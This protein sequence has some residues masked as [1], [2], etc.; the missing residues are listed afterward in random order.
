VGEWVRAGGGPPERVAEIDN[1]EGEGVTSGSEREAGDVRG[2]LARGHPVPL[3]RQLAAGLEAAIRDGHL[4]PGARLPSTRDLA[5]RLGVDRSTVNA[6]YA[7]LRRRGCVEGRARGRLAVAGDARPPEPPSR[8]SA[9]AGRTSSDRRAGERAGADPEGRPDPP[10]PGTLAADCLGAMLRS[11]AAA[12]VPRRD[13][14]AALARAVS[15]LDAV[16]EV[17]AAGAPAPAARSRPGTPLLVEPRPGLRRALAAELERRLGVPV[18]TAR[19]IPDAGWRG[20]VL[21]RPEVLARPGALARGRRSGPWPGALEVLPLPLA[22][23]TRERGLVR[24][25]VRG[26][27]VAL[28][29]VSGSVRRYARELAA[30]E[31][32]RGVSFT[33]LDPRDTP[34]VVRAVGVARLVLHDEASR[35]AIPGTPAASAVIRLIRPGPIAALRGY[36]GL[37]PVPRD[38]RR[39]T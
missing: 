12:A 11:A 27:V 20:P 15:D 8:G 30:R 35:G 39:G 33:A 10:A 21:A 13:V 14:L 26:G 4:G 36:L 38:P 9:T 37:D 16:V 18:E 23:G 7:R 6:A 3:G 32:E 17:G 22:G 19:A 5:R 25:S 24:R 1:R 34:A 31:F 29:S 28:V 2:P